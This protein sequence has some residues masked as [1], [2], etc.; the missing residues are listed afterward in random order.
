MATTQ[1]NSDS[2]R[3]TGYERHIPVVPA[4]LKRWQPR[5]STIAHNN[6]L[7]PAPKPYQ[8]LGDEEKQGYP[9]PGLKGGQPTKPKKQKKIPRQSS[10]KKGKQGQ[11]N[12]A[13]VQSVQ[14]LLGE[15][16]AMREAAIEPPFFPGPDGETVP[17][18]PEPT[19]PPRE[20]TPPPPGPDPVC[21]SGYRNYPIKVQEEEKQ[22]ERKLQIEDL[23]LFHYNAYGYS[24][25]ARNAVNIKLPTWARITGIVSASETILRANKV[26]Y[27]RQRFTDHW[28]EIKGL[29]YDFDYANPWWKLLAG[30][31]TVAGLADWMMFFPRS[32]IIAT[33]AVTTGLIYWFN[34]GKTKTQL[35]QPLV[36]DYCTGVTE[37]SSYV[38]D[39]NSKLKWPVANKWQCKAR[40]F[41]VGFTFG[42]P[43][44]WIPRNCTHNE[45]NSLITR[46]LQ[47]R[48][49]VTDQGEWMWE[50]GLNILKRL[51]PQISPPTAD[52]E[53]MQTYFLEKY[54]LAQRTRI[55][56]S[57]DYKL[58]VDDKV[59]A[60]PKI[61]VMTGKPEA[62]RKV[63]CIS[64]FDE[65]F[66]L[67][68]GPEFYWYQKVFCSTYWAT[69]EQRLTT[70]LLYTGA[71]RADEIGG[72][73]STYMSLGWNF[74]LMDFGKF[75]S[76]NKHKAWETM[77][78]YFGPSMTN[79]WNTMIKGIMDKRGRTRSGIT[80]SVEGTTPSGWI[81]TSL[82]NTIIV[83]IVLTA[84]FHEMGVDQYYVSALGD[85]NNTA[86]PEDVS[87]TRVTQLALEM[88]HELEGMWVTPETYH[89][90][91]YCSNR[92]WETS[93]GNHVLGMKIGRVL[94]KTFVCHKH[95]PDDCIE[96]HI[97]GVLL[98][99]K[100]YRWIPVFGAVYQRW[101]ECHPNVV[102][103][104]YYAEKNPYQITLTNEIPVDRGTVDEFFRMVYGFDPDILE[105]WILQLDFPIGA[106]FQHPLMDEIM[107][108]DGVAYDMGIEDVCH[109]YFQM[110]T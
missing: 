61:E 42:L 11:V 22:E 39:K 9:L 92:V 10:K 63:R 31:Y 108:I 6:L 12:Q 78:E 88:G 66:L 67:R 27:N 16:D 107:R 59:G 33:T 20:P 106:V 37:R 72:W 64:G 30:V 23:A 85:D 41:P 8:V 52:E 5:P 29:M 15:V 21:V 73:F 50:N 69:Q 19:P 82:G 71:M 98:G 93:P 96:S 90:A 38:L 24:Y 60:F 36:K 28:A 83:F 34:R 13:L 102:P 7:P 99:F 75:D 48:I 100:Q 97:A 109:S 79:G 57:L 2:A 80:F 105:K 84:I 53:T 17:P 51:L 40:Y 4:P 81:G 58:E 18:Q 91:E 62:K 54:P 32:F 46:Q 55:A 26:F 35:V 70:V 86:T 95:V 14:Q 3:T 87:I 76:R 25:K 101:F 47:P 103:R 77:C 104:K 110:V 49:E 45:A 89:L 74:L 44:I 1:G 56:H 43:W 65:G 94:A 68:T